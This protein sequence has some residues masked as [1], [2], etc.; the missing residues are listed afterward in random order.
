MGKF[1]FIKILKNITT[2]CIFTWLPKLELPPP[3]ACPV[4][5]PQQGGEREDS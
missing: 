3:L 4:I 2:F 5:L 1:N